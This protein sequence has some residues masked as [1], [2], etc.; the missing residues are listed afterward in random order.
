MND[1]HWNMFPFNPWL[2]CRSDG[3]AKLRTVIIIV[4]GHLSIDFLLYYIE[5]TFVNIIEQAADFVKSPTRYANKEN[6]D[7]NSA[8]GICINVN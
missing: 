6:I 8:T 2:D 5:H 7:T 4:C 3:I 1:T